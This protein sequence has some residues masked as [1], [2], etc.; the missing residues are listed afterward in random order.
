MRQNELESAKN[1]KLSDNFIFCDVGQ[2]NQTSDNFTPVGVDAENADSG[3]A[4]SSIG[5][6]QTIQTEV[7]FSSGGSPPAIPADV[8]M[9]SSG[10]DDVFSLANGQQENFHVEFDEPVASAY[11]SK[12]TFVES[13]RF[14]HS[15]NDTGCEMD[16]DGA[17]SPRTD[18]KRPCCKTVSKD[19]GMSSGVTPTIPVT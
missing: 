3:F 5:S 17:E 14:S 15:S 7:Q 11:W 16:M 19:S 18:S 12:D 9:T 4:H 6:V 13:Q 8:A 1:T 10:S 2:S